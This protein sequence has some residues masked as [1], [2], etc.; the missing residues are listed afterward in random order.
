[1]SAS[2]ADEARAFAL[3]QANRLEEAESAWRA[4]LGENPEDP[5]AQHFLGCVL[6]RAGRIEEGLRLLDVSLVRE[7]RNAMFLANRAHVLAQAGRL[8]TAIADLRLAL[9]CD[10]R[11]AS[12]SH[13]LGLLLE[14]AGRTDEAVAALRRA[15]SLEAD[16]AGIHATLGRLLLSTGD[17]AGARTT[18]EHAN[19]LRPGDAE[20]LNNLG[21]ALNGLG[22]HDMAIERYREALALKPSFAEARLNWGHVVRDMGDLRA[23]AAM[24]RAAASLRPRFIEAMLAWANAMLELGELAAA[25]EMYEQVLR[26]SP[27]SADALYGSGQVA[28]REHRFR[29]GWAGYEWRFATHP[30]QAKARALALRRLHADDLGHARRVLVWGEQGLGDQ[31]L[32]STLLRELE[33]RGIEI[34]LDLDPRLMPLVLRR[35]TRARAASHPPHATCDA[36]LPLGSLGA[37][38]RPDAASFARQPA[39][40]LRADP[41]RVED[42]RARAGGDARLIGISWRSLRDG[43]RGPL[44]ARKSAPLACFAPLATPGT[45]LLDLQYGDVDEERARFGAR[46]P[47]RLARI[48]GLDT[49]NDL[50]GLVAAIELC[51]LVVTTSNVTAHL[52]GAIGKRTLLGFP[53]GNP[54]FAYWV[55]GEDGRVLWYP[56]VEAVSGPALDTWGKV[57]A[58]IAERAG[59]PPAPA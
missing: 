42:L 27:G 2:G 15:A 49:T 59:A 12:A 51:E 29:E 50:E 44:T 6:A 47:G 16:G 40:F 37:L 10:P 23:A 36:H 20:L 17:A 34:E 13:Q 52:A 45:R 22:L 3:L 57:F 14:R 28:L 7:P 32:F 53:G 33:A 43:G 54:P 55:P 5:R 24:Y 9:E 21:L 26:E 46:F 41:A 25:R 35:L 19:R 30:P 31:V 8:E 4:I 18:L 56:C 38:F 48:E 39:P 11:F 1:M 58:R